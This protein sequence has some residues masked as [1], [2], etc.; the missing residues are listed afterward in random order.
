M[1]GQVFATAGQLGPD[2]PLFHLTCDLLESLIAGKLKEWAAVVCAGGEPGTWRRGWRGLT[3]GA[4]LGALG[5]MVE[6][7][8]FDL[9]AECIAMD[10]ESLG[11]L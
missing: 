8:F 6:A 10:S 7:Q 9:A 4:L 5:P 11:S 3:R 1:R 2:T